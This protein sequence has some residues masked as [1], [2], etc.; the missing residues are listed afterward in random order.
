MDPDLLEPPISNDCVFTFTSLSSADFTFTCTKGRCQHS[1][2][3]LEHGLVPSILL[4]ARDGGTEK[5]GRAGRRSK[6]GAVNRRPAPNKKKFV[7]DEKQ[8]RHKFAKGIS[9]GC[10]NVFKISI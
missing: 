7:H 9:R 1:L 6:F 4:A 5:P 2:F 8:K 10:R 3:L